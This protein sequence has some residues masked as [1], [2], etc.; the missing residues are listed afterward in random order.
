MS[1]RFTV[2]ESSEVPHSMHISLYK[3][4]HTLVR[5]HVEKLL[6]LS[7]MCGIVVAIHKYTC[8]M[9]RWSELTNAPIIEDNKQLNNQKGESNSTTRGSRPKENVVSPSTCM[10]TSPHT[11]ANKNTTAT[12]TML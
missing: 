3:Y 9:A 4:T 12:C 5:V 2:A 11:T 6:A 7:G 10:M 8:K 1:S